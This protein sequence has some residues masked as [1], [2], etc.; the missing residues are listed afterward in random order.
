MVINQL[1]IYIPLSDL[2]DKQAELNRLQKKSTNSSANYKSYQSLK[3]NAD[4]VRKAPAAVVEKEQ[5]N[6][7][8]LTYA[9]HKLQD[10]YSKI[11]TL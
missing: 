4:Y 1:E 6:F 3:K 8:Q 5:Q 7:Q 9:L 10:H 11:S 2:V